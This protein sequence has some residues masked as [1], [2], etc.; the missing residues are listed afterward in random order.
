MRVSPSTEVIG[1]DVGQTIFN[2]RIKVW[3]RRA[4]AWVGKPLIMFGF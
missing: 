3:A 1:E 2:A 4:V